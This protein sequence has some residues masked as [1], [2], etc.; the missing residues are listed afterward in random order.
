MVV[1]LLVHIASTAQ[2]G[3]PPPGADRGPGEGSG[4][5]PQQRCQQRG[6]GLRAHVLSFSMHLP[7]PPDLIRA[8]ETADHTTPCGHRR[9][10]QLSHLPLTEIW[11][12]WPASPFCP[13]SQK[14][15]CHCGGCSPPPDITSIIPKQL[16]SSIDTSPCHPT[17]SACLRG[18]TLTTLVTHKKVVKTLLGPG[19]SSTGAP[20]GR[21]SPTTG[22]RGSG[23]VPVGGGGGTGGW[24]RSHSPD[25]TQAQCSHST[26]AG[27]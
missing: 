16:G 15:S 19:K 3:V 14:S 9:G 27:S 20:Q 8:T 2:A 12:C 22:S 21:D 25:H 5:P 6:K 24:Q 10:D 7:G 4:P 1:Y 18:S 17:W 13:S 11:P 26:V 23:T